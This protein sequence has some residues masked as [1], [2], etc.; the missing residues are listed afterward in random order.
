MRET[1]R[2]VSCYVERFLKGCFSPIMQQMPSQKAGP[3]AKAFGVLQKL[4]LETV[5]GNFRVPSSLE[6]FEGQILYVLEYY[7]SSYNTSLP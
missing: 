7:S 3:T 4:F 2:A 1:G 5:F 6:M